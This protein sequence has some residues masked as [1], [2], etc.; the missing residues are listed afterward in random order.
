MQPAAAHMLNNI[1]CDLLSY[2]NL[3]EWLRRLIR[4]QLGFPAG[5]QISQLSYYIL[6]FCLNVMTA[7]AHKLNMMHALY[8]IGACIIKDAC[9]TTYFHYEGA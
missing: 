9:I 8:Y 5:V 2:G 3:A 7:A 1:L 4:N 6:L